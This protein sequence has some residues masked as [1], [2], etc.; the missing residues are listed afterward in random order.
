MKAKIRELLCSIFN[1]EW[2]EYTD[3]GPCHRA[4][5]CERCGKTENRDVHTM[6]WTP[7]R[8]GCIGA[9]SRCGAKTRQE[10]DLSWEW[11]PDYEPCD[12]GVNM[13]GW[14][15]LW[16]CSRCGYTYRQ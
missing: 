14:P 9:C 7:E 3:I 5:T 1:H 12:D 15:R 10:H 16:E 11:D 13:Q 8:E 6:E 2:G 4:R